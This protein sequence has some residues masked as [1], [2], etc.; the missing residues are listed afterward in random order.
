MTSDIRFI[1]QQKIGEA[2]EKSLAA[3]SAYEEYYDRDRQTNDRIMENLTDKYGTTFEVIAERH[4]DNK[5]NYDLDSIQK[6]IGEYMM[7]YFKSM[8][9]RRRKIIPLRNLH[10]IM[11]SNIDYNPEIDEEKV[12]IIDQGKLVEKNYGEHYNPTVQPMNN[13]D[14]EDKQSGS[15][16]G[17]FAPIISF[18]SFIFIEKAPYTFGIL[19]L[20]ILIATPFIYISYIKKNKK[21]KQ[22]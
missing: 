1:K 6:V 14:E 9:E 18:L 10:S 2:Y 7:P 4:I 22:N 8:I 19:L 3:I 21:K 16:G 11:I 13:E 20:L 17:F 5:K 15:Q 12:F